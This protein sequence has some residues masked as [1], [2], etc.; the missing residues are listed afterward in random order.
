MKPTHLFFRLFCVAVL[1]G[2]FGI[3]AQSQANTPLTITIGSL[4][5]APATISP[6]QEIS[7]SISITANQTI[8]DYPVEFSGVWRSG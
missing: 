1:A 8:S 7:F 3:T 6:G 5:P 4:T 2:I